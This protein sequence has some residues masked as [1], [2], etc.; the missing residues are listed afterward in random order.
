MQN[1]CGKIIAAKY[2]KQLKRKNTRERYILQS[3]LSI[4]SR[5]VGSVKGQVPMCVVKIS[6][7]LNVTKYYEFFSFDFVI[8][9]RVCHDVSSY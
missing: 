9:T 5:G 4:S 1:M 2:L 3:R 7:L 6:L 8:S